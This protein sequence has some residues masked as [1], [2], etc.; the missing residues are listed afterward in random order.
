MTKTKRSLART[1][2]SSAIIALRTQFTETRL[3]RTLRCM[4]AVPCSMLQVHPSEMGLDKQDNSIRAHER[5]IY[6]FSEALARAWDCTA[7]I[8]T[9]YCIY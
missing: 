4:L 3:A 6:E 9:L 2:S 7:F 5:S 1:A 8:T